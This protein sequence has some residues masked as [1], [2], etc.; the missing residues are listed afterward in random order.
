MTQ[1]AGFY[2]S[3]W[4]EVLGLA[5]FGGLLHVI[6]ETTLLGYTGVRP[7]ATDLT[8]LATISIAAGFTLVA[9]GAV[10]ASGLSPRNVSTTDAALARFRRTVWAL[11]VCGYVAVFLK[12]VSYWSGWAEALKLTLFALPVLALC[13][14]AVFRQSRRATVCLAA[15]ACVAATL[16][17]LQWV[18]ASR[19]QIPDEKQ[20][21]ALLRALLPVGL[22]I[23]A[24]LASWKTNRAAVSF[25]SIWRGTP[26]I[27][28]LAVLWAALW[29]VV[30]S[31]P[32]SLLVHESASPGL[33]LPAGPVNIVLV[34]LDTVRA[35]HLDLFGYRRET[36]PNLRRFAREQCQVTMPM[37]ATAP[38]TAPSHGSMFTGL[39]PSVHGAHYPFVHDESPTNVSYP[40]RDDVPT[41]AEF[42]VA[43]GY[44][45]AGIGANFVI[46]SSF[47]LPRGFEYS[48]LTPGSVHLASEL[49]WAYR[50]HLG[51]YASPAE[52]VRDNLPEF[53]RQRAAILNRREPPYRRAREITDNAIHWLEGN[54]EHPFFLFLNY[55]D[56]H[57]PYFPPPEDDERFASRPPGE[58]WQSFPTDRYG[59]RTW[60]EA[61]FTAQEEEF[62]VAQYDAELV[63]M[64]RELGR[65]FEHLRASGLMDQTLV[66]V[67]TDHGEA[68]FDR[69]FLGHGNTLYEAETNGFLLASTPPS[70]G[71]VK[72]SP[73]MQFVDF[74]PTIAASVGAPVPPHIQGAP[75]GQGRDYALQEVFCRDCAYNTGEPRERFRR[76][77]VAVVTGGTKLIRS[78]R[79]PDEVYSLKDGTHELVPQ[80]T[81]D[82]KLL[83]RAQVILNKRGEE[84]ME[85]VA[86]N[87]PD[88]EFLRKARSLGYVK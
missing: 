39:Y 10:V 65:L 56:A 24:L 26:Y 58:D 4:R 15:M 81:P 5:I 18:D 27:A 60:G 83:E 75:W 68:L 28:G 2:K 1:I 41:L 50:L 33:G 22:S 19:P 78:T 66:L 49:A 72:A 38:W 69:G 6:F 86:T 13:G 84:L 43:Q 59:D 30:F 14:F 80:A 48:D 62:L 82:T 52:I 21:T 77:L 55:F 57:T 29:I 42:L 87:P 46:L 23:A 16:C 45:T 67:T 17:T 35:D 64:D 34:V 44:R 63:G 61:E 85:A 7:T 9:L 70:L 32:P 74:F 36:M 71:K 73:L 8:L 25:Q 40:L 51:P 12:T 20:F 79:D 53:L 11:A 88:E 76:E 31:A 47:G 3:A 37:F 54:S